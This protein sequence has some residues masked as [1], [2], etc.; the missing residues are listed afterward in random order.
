VTGLATDLIQANSFDA[1]FRQGN[2]LVTDSR[3]ENGFGSVFSEVN[4][5]ASDSGQANVPHNKLLI[6]FCVRKANGIVANS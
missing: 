2:G 1:E 5:L 3:K 6:S 4:D